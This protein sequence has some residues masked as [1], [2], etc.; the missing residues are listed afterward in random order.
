MAIAKSQ[1]VARNDYG[2]FAAAFQTIKSKPSA[3]G[4]AA[5]HRIGMTFFE[6]SPQPIFLFKH[7][8]SE[9][10]CPLFRIML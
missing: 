6:S 9:N 3:S 8:L 7:D 4:A 5:L 1:A 10:R 2:R